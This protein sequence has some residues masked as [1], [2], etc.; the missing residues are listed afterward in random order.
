MELTKEQAKAFAKFE[1]DQQTKRTRGTG[2][3]LAMAALKAAHQTEWET[4]KVKFG[5]KKGS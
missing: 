4:L 3:R 2:R 5:V 1:Q